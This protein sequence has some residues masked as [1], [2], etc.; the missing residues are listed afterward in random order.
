MKINYAIGSIFHIAKADFLQRVRSYYFL[1]ALGVCVFIMYT[2]IP[3]L[4]A[5][6]KILSLG[7]YRGFYNSAWIGTM[8]AMCA[9][10]YGLICFY[11]VNNSV[12]RDIDTGVGQIISTTRISKLQYL[13][14][15]LISNFTV[16]MIIVLLMAIMT[17]A[18][19]LFRGETKHVEFGKLLLPLVIF[20]VPTMFIIAALALFFD[21]LSGLSRGFINI[22]FF[23]LWILMLS[24]SSAID[25]FGFNSGMTELKR[26]VYTMHSDW[27][28]GYVVGIGYI[29]SSNELKVFTL[30]SIIL[31]SSILLN[32]IFWMA[33]SFG[34][35][36]S[37]SLVFNRFDTSKIKVRKQRTRR[38]AGEKR[39]P[40]YN[41]IIIS[42]IKYHDLPVAKARFSYF[43][44]IMVE[45]KLMLRGKSTLWLIISSGLFIASVFTPMNFAY[46]IA[47]PLLW[48][49]QILNVSQLG[50]R[51]ITHR[52]HEYIFSTAYPLTR[53]LPATLAAASVVMLLLA[54][55]VGLRVLLSGNLYSVYAISVGALF[56]PALAIA[57]GILTGSSK[58]FE[59]IFT[60]M[61]YG[62]LNNVPFFDFIGAIEKSGE[63]GMAH[64]ILAITSGL[65]ILAFS[66]R[67]RQITYI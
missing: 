26:L 59:V 2:F 62:I 52:C 33:V 3:P 66:G 63:M 34:L 39:T 6:Y 21:S 41:N 35:V 47:L 28:G 23:L 55:P 46:K 16:L 65:I 12:Q 31:S 49:F 67:K 53:Q 19:F 58:L 51:E 7:N 48:F 38:F 9:P 27:N 10:F 17:V 30:E 42:R 56:I 43:S 20:T 61:V 1:I 24:K 54:M 15:K 64:Y 60:I 18:M 37:G 29:G 5:G 8:V 36:L 22:A 45:I 50:T 44:L 25:V 11:L 14:G 40:V 13:F 57:S 4:D 32:R